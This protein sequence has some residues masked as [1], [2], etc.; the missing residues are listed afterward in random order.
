MKTSI[1][2]NILSMICVT[3]T[4]LSSLT[5][6][7]P[8]K[9]ST[10]EHVSHHN[11]LVRHLS[12]S[13]PLPEAFI[14]KRK[15]AASQ[16]SHP[17]KIL[18]DSSNVKGISSELREYLVD[19]VAVEGNKVFASKI[20]MKNRYPTTIRGNSRLRNSCGY[21][22]I[23]Q[24]PREYG[25]GSYNADF[26]LFLSTDDTGND[27]TLAYATACNLEYGSKRPNVGFAVFN[28]YYID[29][30][31]GKL[32]NDVATYVHEVL[33]ALVFS[34][35]LWANFP[36]VKTRNRYNR[37][38]YLPQY[39][40]D[41]KGHHY[42]RGPNL[43]KAAQDHFGCKSLDKIPLEDDGGDGSAGGH[44][45]R[46]VFGDETMVS[47]DVGI[48]KFS[49]MT[50]AL[51]ADSGWYAIDMTRGDYYTWGKGEGC[52]LFNKYSGQSNIEETCDKNNEF[53]CDK[54]FK[55]KM[56]CEQTTFTGA[57]KIKTKG[58]S[59]H[60]AHVGMYFFEGASYDSKCQEFYYKTRK[61]SGCVETQCKRDIR[62]NKWT[63]Q[64]TLRN[65]ATSRSP[66]VKYTCH[67]ENQ[68]FEWSGVFKF[69]CE[70]PEVICSDRCPKSCNHRGKCLDNG[71]C[72]CDPFYSGEICGTYDGCGKLSSKL[73]KIVVSANKIDTSRKSNYYTTNDY[74]PKYASLSSWHDFTPRVLTD[75]GIDPK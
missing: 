71:K 43:L 10:A 32:D 49:K 7:T 14:S 22:R 9:Q 1:T 17:F 3:M 59:C 25:M 72:D 16:G 5:A 69:V 52:D 26:I 47:E 38:D 50:L 67:S 34:S 40:V 70:N 30:S 42:L 19:L 53:G 60:K 31:K 27:G 35:Q 29:P 58:N 13:D 73:C 41:T 15:L 2:K 12:V 21:E 23:V 37:Y 57:R 63:Y 54:T 18:V 36:K 4:L 61:Y 56:S 20:F 55:Y 8:N 39:F 74:N 11:Y 28:P 46:I 75:T 62:T 45:E 66:N 6:T 64:V 44:F 24:I 65:T 51:L 33:H 48:A 68:V